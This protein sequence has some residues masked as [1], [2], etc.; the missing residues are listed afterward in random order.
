[1][2]ALTMKKLTS[3]VKKTFL[4]NPK[5]VF[6]FLI[7]GSPLNASFMHIMHTRKLGRP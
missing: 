5:N 3:P 7:K 6:P 4:P 1:M 2:V